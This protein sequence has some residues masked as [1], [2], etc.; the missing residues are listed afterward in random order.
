MKLKIIVIVLV[1]GFTKVL[2]QVKETEIHSKTKDG[3]AKF[4]KFTETIVSDEPNSI[5]IFLKSQYKTSSNVEFKVKK[6]ED[7][8]FC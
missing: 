2:S 1:L 5:N 4:I 8:F 6:E 7:C 3:N